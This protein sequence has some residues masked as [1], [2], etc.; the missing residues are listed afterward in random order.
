MNHPWCSDIE[1]DKAV[2][3]AEDAVPRPAL[4]EWSELPK[5]VAALEAAVVQLQQHDP[6]PVSQP[7]LTAEE[8]EA[9]RKLHRLLKRVGGE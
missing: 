1:R 9:V 7:L 6:S 4:P 2:R 3:A 8:R 5:R